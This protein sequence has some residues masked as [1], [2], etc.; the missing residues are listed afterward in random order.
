MFEALL[1]EDVPWSEVMIWQVDERV[2]PTAIR[3][4]TPGNWS[5]CRATSS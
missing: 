3:P 4:A 1:A 2:A 5:T